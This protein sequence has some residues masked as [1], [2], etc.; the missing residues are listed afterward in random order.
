MT[1]FRIITLVIGLFMSGL[2]YVRFVCFSSLNTEMKGLLAFVFILMGSTFFL[3][4]PYFERFVGKYYSV[5]R[6]TLY[7]IFIML[8]FLFSLTLTMD[9]FIGGFSKLF[10]KKAYPFF[11]LN[12]LLWGMSVVLAF[13]ALYEGMK[14]PNLKKV[15]ITHEKIISQKKIVLLS[16]LHI[17]RSLNL[18]KLDRIV[19]KTNA[20]SPNAILLIGD[21]ID[22]KIEFIQ[23]YLK[24]LQRLKAKEG[25]FFVSGNHE[26]Y[27]NDVLTSQTLQNLGF[28]FL[29]NKGMKVTEDIFIAGV[30]DMHSLFLSKKKYDLKQIFSSSEEQHYKILLSHTPYYF[31]NNLFDLEVAGHTHGGQIFP[32]TLLVKRK[33]PYVAGLYNLK[34]H[35]IYVTRGAGQW[36]PQMRFLAPSE[37]TLLILNPK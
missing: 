2:L 36:G 33:V 8:F 6:H 14:V 7:F 15:E 35:S 29:E 18:N 22:D 27:Y 1:F 20:L 30:P 26:V 10:F 16:D 37:I 34:E 28:T 3:T 13:F 9:I 31:K 24:V 5:Y 17:H 25:V 32:F 4:D 23:P 21:I 11:A 12:P 19:Q